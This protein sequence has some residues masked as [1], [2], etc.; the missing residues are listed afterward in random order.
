MTNLNISVIKTAKLTT[1]FCLLIGSITRTYTAKAFTM[2]SAS[3]SLNLSS[4]FSTTSNTVKN[5]I[6]MNSNNNNTFEKGNKGKVLVLG[7]SG[8]LGGTVARRAILE[9]YTVTSI[10]R[11]GKPDTDAN[12][13]I[14]YRIGDAREKETIE[15]ILNEGG[16]KAVIHCIGLLFDG[17]SGIGNLNKF[18][19]GSGSVPDEMS[20]YDDITRKTAF[21]AIDAAESYAKKQKGIFGGIGGN[22]GNNEPLPFIFTSAAEAGWPD[23][24]GGSIVESYL[25]PDWLKRYLVAKRAVES[26]LMDNQTLLRPVI[27]RPSLIFSF[28]R[29]ASLPP[30]GAFFV[31]NKIGLPFV[32]RPVTVQALSAAVI[33]SLSSPNVSGVQRYMQIDELSK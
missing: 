6:Q 16:Y 24:K 7:G 1:T 4:P 17:E 30:V 33:K 31:G 12:E 28:D 22:D 25:A 32:D 9:G 21:N 23:M 10:S 15:R 27:F 14:D 20:S 11:R 13:N 18:V 19:S 2:T 3:S 26:R 29:L 5:V 8:F